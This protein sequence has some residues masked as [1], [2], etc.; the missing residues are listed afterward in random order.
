MGDPRFPGVPGARIDLTVILRECLA[1]SAGV[2][3]G[4]R[5]S[6]ARAARWF[7][8]L[9][10]VALLAAVVVAARHFSE[11]R[12]FVRILATARPWWLLVAVALQVG[13]YFA[14]GETWRVVT[15]AAGVFVPS[16]A[17]FKLSLAK[18]FVDQA[19]P[20]GGISGTLV[21]G[22]SL[23]DRGVPRGV[24]MASIVVDNVSYYVVHV[25]ALAVAV[26]ITIV[27]GQLGPLLLV[28]TF[29]FV[30]MSVAMT[31]ASL[32]LS[33]RGEAVPKAIVRVPFLEKVFT[34]FGQAD[35][36]LARSPG[37]ILLSS[38]YQLL[39]VLLDAATLWV[40]VHSVGAAAPFAGVF[41]SFMISTLLRIIALVPGGLGAFEAGSVV[42]LKLAGVPVGVALAATLLFRGLTFWLPMI[43]GLLYSRPTRPHNGK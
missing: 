26:G 13:T 27:G 22:R 17:A 35:V 1:S 40:L 8:W 28:P 9:F 39:I 31:V 2:A 24:V 38:V 5:V 4:I 37:L 3:G 34:L 41:A 6:A 10:G 16:T 21:V 14:Q 19:L 32:V 18:L 15:R 23:E 20:S 43:P 25:L 30:L 33:G 12:Q 7:S 11:G 36:K 29:L 42:T